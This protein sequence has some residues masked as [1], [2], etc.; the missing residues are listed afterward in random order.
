MANK[1]PIDELSREDMIALVHELRRQPAPFSK[2][3]PVEDPQLPGRKKGQGPSDRRQAPVGEPE[4]GMEAQA[5]PCCPDCG[6]PLEETG[7]EQATATELAGQPKP[8]VTAYRVAVC[9]CRDCGKKVR[10]TAPGL[11]ADQYGATA[12]R[13]G[14]AVM[15]AAHSLHYGMGIPVRKVPA[16]LKELSGVRITQ[17]ALTQDALRRAKGEVGDR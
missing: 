8:L 7:V 5:P 14:P 6:G 16:V 3:K 4:V 12:H 1:P 11:A 10:E 17:S 13:V 15:A 2:D 9:R